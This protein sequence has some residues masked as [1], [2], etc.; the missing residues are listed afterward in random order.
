[1]SAPASSKFGA[2]R[3]E[4]MRKRFA[5]IRVAKYLGTSGEPLSIA[6]VIEALEGVAKPKA[7]QLMSKLACD[8]AAAWPTP[9]PKAA[10]E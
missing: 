3:H 8:A 6:R 4:V 5:A 7:R 1:M 2:S 10:T 9:E